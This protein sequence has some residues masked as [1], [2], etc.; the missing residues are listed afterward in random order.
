MDDVQHNLSS[1]TLNITTSFPTPSLT[2]LSGCLTDLTNGVHP[3]QLASISDIS[4]SSFWTYENETYTWSYVLNNAS[5]RYNL[6][7]NWGFSFIILFITSLLFALWAIGTYALWL[8]LQL[9]DPVGQKV[10]TPGTTGI[11]RSSWDLVEAL[12]NDFGDDVVQP[13]LR[14]ADIRSM[15]RRR[16][17]GGATGVRSSHGIRVTACAEVLQT[18]PEPR[19]PPMWPPDSYM[20]PTPWQRLRSLLQPRS[21]PN[22]PFL[23]YGSST[24][25]QAHILHTPA[26]ATISV[27]TS[28]P[29]SITS[30]STVF[31]FSSALPVS[32]SPSMETNGAALFPDIGERARR[33]TLKGSR[34]SSSSYSHSLTP[35]PSGSLAPGWLDIPTAAGLK[36]GKVVQAAASRKQTSKPCDASDRAPNAGLQFKYDLG[37]DQ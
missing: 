2:T 12:K 27:G 30:P 15:V 17:K 34:F 35:S 5:C 20:M 33:P 1:P 11:Y 9:H 6:H 25:S 8:F 18:S 37:D 14:D 32:P 24:S 21:N 36:G 19:A 16:A 13:E 29:T 10:S 22:E 4:P 3:S 26:A 7:H 31:S 23:P 28:S